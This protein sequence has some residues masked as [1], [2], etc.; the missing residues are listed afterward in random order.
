MPAQRPTIMSS[1][2][3]GVN[4]YASVALAGEGEEP[5]SLGTAYGEGNGFPYW[6]GWGLESPCE[7]RLEQRQSC[8]AC[9]WLVQVDVAFEYP[10]QVPNGY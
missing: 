1:R 9:T 2:S 3:V 6:L 5:G 7:S 4:P 8:E 10:A